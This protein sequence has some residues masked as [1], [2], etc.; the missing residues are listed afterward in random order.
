MSSRTFAVSCVL[1]AALSVLSSA[2]PAAIVLQGSFEGIATGSRVYG[3]SVSGFDGEA[4]TGTFSLDLP[5][6]SYFTLDAPGRHEELVAPGTVKL[7]FVAHGRSV[8]FSGSFQQAARIVLENDPT[9]KRLYLTADAT[10]PY[11]NALLQLSGNLFDT[12]ELASIHPG[13][14]DLGRSYAGFVA[15]RFFG[16]GVALTRLS[17]ASPIPEPSTTLLMLLGLGA[18]SFARS[19]RA[20]SFHAAVATFAHRPRPPC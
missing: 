4:V 11:S 16:A 13:D 10:D 19:R 18:V 9:G 1:G 8:D 17:F 3:E 12:L 5:A 15:G 20:S 6:A 14:V 7:G 2:A